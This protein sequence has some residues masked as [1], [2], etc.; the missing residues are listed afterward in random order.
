MWFRWMEWKIP[1][2][3]WH[4]YFLNDPMINLTPHQIKALEKSPQQN[5]SWRK[6]TGIR[7]HLLS[8]FFENVVLGYLETMQRKYFFLIPTRNLFARKFVKWVRLLA[9]LPEYIFYNV[10]S[11]EVRKISEVFWAKRYCK[12]SGLFC[13]FLLALRLSTKK[14]EINR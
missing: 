10:D 13:K 11:V 8:K 6:F 7:R 3:K 12:I 1:L 5:F 14:Y 2:C 4:S 9:V